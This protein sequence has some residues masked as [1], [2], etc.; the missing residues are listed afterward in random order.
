MSGRLDIRGGGMGV[1]RG[2][3]I[4]EIYSWVGEGEEEEEDGGVKK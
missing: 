1:R 3:G 4:G 2:G